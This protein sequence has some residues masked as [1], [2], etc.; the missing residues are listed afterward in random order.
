MIELKSA[1]HD[2]S[3]SSKALEKIEKLREMKI[4]TT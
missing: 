2:E 4:L 1:D 3:T